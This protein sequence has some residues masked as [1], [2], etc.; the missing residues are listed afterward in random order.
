MYL[1]MIYKIDEKIRL[2]NVTNFRK[3]LEVNFRNKYFTIF[4]VCLTIVF[5]V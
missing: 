1:K 2:L 5:R 4:I 3:E